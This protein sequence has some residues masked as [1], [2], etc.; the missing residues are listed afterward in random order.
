MVVVTIFSEHRARPFE[1]FECRICSEWQVSPW[2]GWSALAWNR[3]WCDAFLLANAWTCH[4]LLERSYIKKHHVSLCVVILNSFV[5]FWRVLPLLSAGMWLE[6]VG[7]ESN[8]HGGLVHAEAHGPSY[9]SYWGCFNENSVKKYHKTVALCVFMAYL[10]LSI[11][12]QSYCTKSIASERLTFEKK[13]PGQ[14]EKSR[15]RY[16]TCFHC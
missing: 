13:K 10:S 2:V 9:R 3:R 5:L 11:S 16:L 7:H 8:L 12:W 14:N 6:L 1:A 15:A 4:F